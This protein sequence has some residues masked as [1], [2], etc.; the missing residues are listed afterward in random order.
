MEEAMSEERSLIR[1]TLLCAAVPLGL[2]L[3]PTLPSWQAAAQVP[4]ETSYDMRVDSHIGLGYIANL[5]NVST[6]LS[7]FHLVRGG[8]G[9]F[10]DVKHTLD[11]QEDDRYFEPELTP[12][13]AE[14]MGHRHFND[15]KEYTAGSAGVMWAFHEEV[16]VYVGAGYSERRAF[17]GFQDLRDD[18]EERIGDRDG[19]YWVRDAEES[20]RGLN[21]TAG[22]VFQAGDHLFIRAGGELFPAGANAGVVLALPR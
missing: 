10:V 22:L 21:A 5:P 3:A 12:D 8:W 4:G 1:Y 14:F 6:G 11:T 2:A 7:F 16:A 17:S 19:H 9:Y 18:E 15:A 20:R 13:T